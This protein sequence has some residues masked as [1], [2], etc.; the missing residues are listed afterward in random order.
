MHHCS[1]GTANQKS[2]PHF[3]TKTLYAIELVRDLPLHVNI[4]LNLLQIVFS[5][6][7]MIHVPLEY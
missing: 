1:S 6:T 7:I 2:K 5:K 4:F 3:V